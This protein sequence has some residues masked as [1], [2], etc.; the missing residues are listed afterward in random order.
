MESKTSEIQNDLI[1]VFNST[2]LPGESLPY[3]G[4]EE[5]KYINDSGGLTDTLASFWVEK[6]DV[7]GKKL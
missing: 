3:L 4:K 6:Y 1:I 5:A 2:A 7:T